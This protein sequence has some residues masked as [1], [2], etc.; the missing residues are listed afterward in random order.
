MK[1]FP[2]LLVLLASPLAHAHPDHIAGQ[3]AAEMAAAAKI[4]L[5]TLTEDQSAA[6]VFKFADDERENWHFVPLDRKGIRLSELKPAQDH[7][8]YALLGTGLSQK[9]LLTAATV[10]SLEQFLAEKENNPKRR[11]TEKY[12][13]AIFGEP[14]ATTTWGWRFEGHHL[15]LNFTL[16]DGKTVRTTPAFFGTNPAE[17]MDG[18]RRGLRPLGAIE[19]AAR[20]LATSLQQ[21]GKPL[22]FSDQAPR[23]VLTGQDR[24]AKVPARQGVMGSDMSPA[25]Q[26]Q[27]LA[28]IREFASLGRPEI[29]GRAMANIE[30]ATDQL[31]F[32]WAGGLKPGDP[33]Y[34]RILAGEVFLIEYANT[35]NDANHAHVVWRVFNGDFGRDLLREHLKDGH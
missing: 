9:G 31:Q 6:T 33:H 22:V 19:D 13:L 15:S 24:R 1:N 2:L 30:K 26:Q 29:T 4:F 25:Q 5:A 14:S 12:Y 34:F 27:L 21:A 28:T 16:V 3:P 10:M 23:D 32:A 18:P 8:A 35:Q 17:I 20:L 7:L 11:D